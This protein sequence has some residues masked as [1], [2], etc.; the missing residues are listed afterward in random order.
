MGRRQAVSPG[1]I[2]AKARAAAARHRLKGEDLNF[3]LERA[4]VPKSKRADC[5]R[6]I[7]MW[8]EWY[9]RSI[10][11]SE[12]TKASPAESRARVATKARDL[13]DELTR[14]TSELRLKVQPDFEARDRALVEK[15][16][17]IHVAKADAYAAEA[18]QAA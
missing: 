3:Y 10:A 13:S 6:D 11:R 9:Q 2:A 18:A 12:Q 1:M 5:T 4:G 14:L 17:L 16:L 8:F 15:H 7:K